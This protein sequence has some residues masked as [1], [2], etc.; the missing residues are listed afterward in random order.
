MSDAGQPLDLLNRSMEERRVR[1][2]SAALPILGVLIFMTPIIR[3]FAG[4]GTV[5]GLPVTFLFLFGCW[6]VL[7]MIARRLSHRL[8]TEPGE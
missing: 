3:V 4:A 1:D 6:L 7:I 2:M 8:I 5:L